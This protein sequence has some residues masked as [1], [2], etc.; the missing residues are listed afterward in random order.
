MSHLEQGK[1]MGSMLQYDR[2]AVAAIDIPAAEKLVAHAHP[3]A[4]ESARHQ[5]DAGRAIRH[6]QRQ[7]VADR[8]WR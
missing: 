7:A 6:R 2:D 1:D 4:E 8:R 3:G 5:R